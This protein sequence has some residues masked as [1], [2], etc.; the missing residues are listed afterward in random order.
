MSTEE[1]IIHWGQSFGDGFYDHHLDSTLVDELQSQYSF[2]KYQVHLYHFEGIT[3]QFLEGL[4]SA[5]VGTNVL[6]NITANNQSQIPLDRTYCFSQI[7]DQINVVPIPCALTYYRKTVDH[8]CSF[9]P[10]NQYQTEVITRYVNRINQNLSIKVER[11]ETS[12]TCS[13]QLVCQEPL[14]VRLLSTDP[15][16]WQS[17]K[18]FSVVSDQLIN[19]IKLLQ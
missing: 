6:E 5:S 9:Q 2:Q 12:G 14:F 1:W 3:Y 11:D 10:V 17:L 19:V 15:D 16:Q 13:L 7:V 18:K 8:S 4:R